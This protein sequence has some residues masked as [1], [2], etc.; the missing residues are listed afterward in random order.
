[1]DTPSSNKQ[2]K[3]AKREEEGTQKEKHLEHLLVAELEYHQ[4]GKKKVA[5]PNTYK[6]N[7]RGK[8]RNAS[9]RKTS[10]PKQALDWEC[11]RT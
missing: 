11:D 5:G 3:K 6:V 4:K 8:K 10:R 2:T 7:P 1:V 9:T